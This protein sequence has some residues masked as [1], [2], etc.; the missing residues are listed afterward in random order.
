MRIVEVGIDAEEPSLS[1]Y[2]VVGY[3]GVGS[4]ASAVIVTPVAS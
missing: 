1:G 3:S 2:T 4:A